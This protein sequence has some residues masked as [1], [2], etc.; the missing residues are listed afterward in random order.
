MDD[1]SII[2]MIRILA[3]T[4]AWLDNLEA[5][6][7][8][9]TFLDTMPNNF[10]GRLDIQK[11][12]NELTGTL[13]KVSHKRKGLVDQVLLKFFEQTA[14][15]YQV[16]WSGR[17]DHICC[18]PIG[19][20]R[21]S[22][23]LLGYEEDTPRDR[24]D[25]RL[26]APPMISPLSSASSWKELPFPKIK[27]IDWKSRGDPI[28]M[29]GLAVV[30]RLS[31]GI[32]AKVGRIDPGEAQA[33]DFF[34]RHLKAVPVWDYQENLECPRSVAKEVCPVHGIRPKEGIIDPDQHMCTCYG[35]QDV[36]LMPEADTPWIDTKSEEYQAFMLGFLKECHQELDRCWDARPS[37]VA[38]Y[39][40]NLVALDFGEEE[41]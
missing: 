40:G 25:L 26:L 24:Q 7:G 6:V 12:L 3:L 38:K 18:W 21:V 16:K 8:T 2:E 27:S 23:H 37:N 20:D 31:P 32:V 14:Q 36:L 5:V 29:G 10:G 35:S 28:G 4:Q 15:R 17:P 1:Q 33:Q 39:L 34:A 41:G 19:Q 22:L 11:M 30:Y 13:Q 9:N